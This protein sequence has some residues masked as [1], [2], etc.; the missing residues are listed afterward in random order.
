MLEQARRGVPGRE[1]IARALRTI[2]RG[3]AIALPY[4]PRRADMNAMTTKADIR[5]I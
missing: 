3:T 2:V 4:C 1:E 5:S